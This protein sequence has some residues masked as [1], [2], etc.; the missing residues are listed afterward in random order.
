VTSDRRIDP[1]ALLQLADHQRAVLACHRARLQLLGQ[2]SVRQRRARDHEQPAGVLVEAMHDAAPRKQPQRRVPVQQPVLQ[3]AMPIA[4]GRVND[5]PSRLVDHQQM[6]VLEHDI[7]RQRLR[8]ALPDR[9]QQ[10]MDPGPLA[11][12][13]PRAGTASSTVDAHHSGLDPALDPAAR[14]L[15]KAGGQGLIQAPA[16]L[17]QVQDQVPIEPDAVAVVHIVGGDGIDQGP[18]AEV[19][20]GHGSPIYFWVVQSPG[21][22][23][24]LSGSPPRIPNLGHRNWFI[25]AG[26][27]HPPRHRRD[28]TLRVRL[29]R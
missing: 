4:G 29:L 25:H 19:T 27:D 23:K 12:T 8:P 18:R 13:N 1:T 9:L 10:C 26:S 17:R 24:R 3:R 21:N 11:A 22:R 7:E 14:E 2:R 5:E 15:R 28:R 16:V 20:V 6:L